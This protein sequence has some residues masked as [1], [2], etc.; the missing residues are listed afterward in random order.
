MSPSDTDTL[1]DANAVYTEVQQFYAQHMHLLDAGDATGWAATFT[2]DATVQLPGQAPVHTRANLETAV[3]ANLARMAERH[4]THRH[5]HGMVAV[6]P[7][8]EDEIRV[9]CY[10]LVFAT[11]DG[12]DPWLHRA[13]T[14]DDKLVR[15][16]G[17]WFVRQRR[18][19]RDGHPG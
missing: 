6:E 18:V 19:T 12:G 16:G 11:R 4:E 2:E 8:S 10:A 14:C 5:W 9:H 17:R 1:I 15:A 3:R 7:V 13:C